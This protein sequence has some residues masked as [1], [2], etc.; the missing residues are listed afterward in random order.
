M[1]VQRY[2]YSHNGEDGVL[3]GSAKTM[4]PIGFRP[5]TATLSRCRSMT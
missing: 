2:L 5:R 3:C 4:N 1:S